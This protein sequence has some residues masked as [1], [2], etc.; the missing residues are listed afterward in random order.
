MRNKW[1]KKWKGN[2]TW[3]RK[4]WV[5][6][7]NNTRNGFHFEGFSFFI[8]TLSSF[9]RAAAAFSMLIF[10]PAD[11]ILTYTSSHERTGFNMNTFNYLAAETLRCFSMFLL[12]HVRCRMFIHVESCFM[13]NACKKMFNCL[14]SFLC[15]FVRF[16]LD[17]KLENCE[18]FQLCTNTNATWKSVHQHRKPIRWMEEEKESFRYTQYLFSEWN[19]SRGFER[20]CWWNGNEKK[21][22][23][24]LR[25]NISR[26]EK[27]DGAKLV[28]FS[29]K[30]EKIHQKS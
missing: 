10:F 30:F 14:K 11:D 25:C 19:R 27:G 4:V 15:V 22:S 8:G 28:V 6:A 17:E 3:Q 21:V 23:N 16:F 12:R 18:N 24:R 20:V 2:L 1:G 7:H 26:L 29:R 5:H 13:I 9:L